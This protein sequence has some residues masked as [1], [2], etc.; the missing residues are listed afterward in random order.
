MGGC[1]PDRA[2]GGLAGGRARVGQLD[3]VVDRVAHQVHERIAQLVRDRA[4]HLHVAA[5][6]AE[7]HILAQRACRVPHH[8]RQPLEDIAQR[9]HAHRENA[10]L[11]L[12]E[13]AAHPVERGRGAV[14]RGRSDA[15][16]Q[17]GQLADPLRD[18]IQHCAIDAHMVRAGVRRGWLVRGRLVL[19]RDLRHLA[20]GPDR[21]LRR[22]LVRARHQPQHEVALQL[23]VET[24]GD[25]H[26]PH[27][28]A[29]RRAHDQ[30]R[31]WEPAGAPKPGEEVV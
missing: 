22:G 19:E 23:R 31:D 4:V 30:Q 16:V 29:L 7:V 5:L 25:D 20:R 6:H 27:A 26:P 21:R 17:H 9:H 10:A 14:H 15:R 13:H 11:Q 12:R 8:A 24:R 18:V 2:L 28:G 3:A 1:D